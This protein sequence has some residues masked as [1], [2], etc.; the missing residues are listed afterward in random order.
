MLE[1][2]ISLDL[3]KIAFLSF[4]FSAIIIGIIG[5]DVFTEKAQDLRRKADMDA[6]A[7]ALDMYYLKHG[8]YPD[9][10]DDWRGWDLSYASGKKSD[11]LKI[12][13]D[14]GFLKKEARDPVNDATYYYRYQR[15]KAGSFGCDKA[16]YVLQLSS[17]RLAAEST[18]RGECPQIRWTD[19]APNGYTIQAFE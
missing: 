19:L 10:D 8:A 7:K 18:G 6:L 16:F 15:F 12:L 17:F 14:E 4:I 9:S 3:K 1:R 11:F 5:F 2:K 13:V